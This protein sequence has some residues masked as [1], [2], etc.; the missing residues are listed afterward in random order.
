[1]Q[2]TPLR[3]SQHTLHDLE[4][5]LLLFFTGYSRDADRILID[6]KVRSEK[7]DGGMLQS[8]RAIA[9]IGCRVKDALETGDTHGFAALMREHWELKRVRSQGM[10]SSDIDRWHDVAMQNGALGGKLVGAGGGGFLMFYADDPSR[11]R[12][13]MEAESLAEVRFHF[14]FDGSTVIVRG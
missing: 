2:V 5:H 12:R 11:L 14:D 6:Q 4:E 1:V 7:G 3:I 9:D 8:M 10:S 13:A